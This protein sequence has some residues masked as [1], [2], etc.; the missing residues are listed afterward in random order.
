MYVCNHVSVSA[1]IS[2]LTVLMTE[3]RDSRLLVTLR[4]F[5]R[6]METHDI[7]APAPLACFLAGR[8][9]GRSRRTRQKRCCGRGL[10][11]W[12]QGGYIKIAGVEASYARHC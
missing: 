5:A 11:K 1:T 8:A 6:I 12:H 2:A 4:V 9:A 10:G 3:L 7:G